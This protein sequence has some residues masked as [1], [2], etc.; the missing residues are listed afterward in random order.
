MELTARQ[1]DAA[2]RWA[3]TGAAADAAPLAAVAALDDGALDPVLAGV[4]AVLERAWAT[5]HVRRWRAGERVDLVGA[6]GP[7]GCAL[8]AGPPGPDVPLAV[9]HRPRATTVGRAV[10]AFVGLG[11]TPA[12]A[13]VGRAEVRWD[14]LVA[15]PGTLW[16]L[17]W[18]ADAGR[19]SPARLTVLAAPSA[20]LAEVR[21]AS[22]APDAPMLLS[23]R[24][25][26]EVWLGL[27]HLVARSLPSDRTPPSTGPGQP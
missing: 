14:E 16:D 22:P 13:D 1:V 19:A 12:D 18:R 7:S 20:A 23:R 17:A 4:V 8:L 26:D 24:R 15:T 10:A 2:R 27:C 9:G 21:P 3:R 25:P 6:I 5:F 11:P